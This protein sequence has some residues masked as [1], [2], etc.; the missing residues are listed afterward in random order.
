MNFRSV[1]EPFVCAERTESI[2]SNALELDKSL[3]G[4]RDSEQ[5]S[6]FPNCSFPIYMKDGT[7]GP[8]P[9]QTVVSRALQEPPLNDA[10]E[11]AGIH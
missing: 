11:V 8:Q 4:L 7:P 10:W 6:L 9:L 2:V 1:H 5:V 3:S